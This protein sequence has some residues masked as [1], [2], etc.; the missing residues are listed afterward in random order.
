L[1]DNLKLK[2]FGLSYTE[3]TGKTNG[4]LKTI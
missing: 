2:I 4:V 1:V 3:I